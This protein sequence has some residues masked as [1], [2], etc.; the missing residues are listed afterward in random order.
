MALC[1][2]HPLVLCS[3]SSFNCSHPLGGE[4]GIPTIKRFHTPAS[5]SPMYS[6]GGKQRRRSAL[7]S[8]T[9]LSSL[10][11]AASDVFGAGASWLFPQ[12]Q[13]PMSEGEAKAAGA[14]WLFPQQ[15]QPMAEGEGKAAGA[16][17]YSFDRGAV[18]FI[19]LDSE[20]PSGP[21]SGQGR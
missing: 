4:C 2:V 14:P 12:K 6:R 8:S 21:E 15:Q 18:H 7:S 1:C 9:F 16:L 10:L 5:G 19:I 20:M 13:Q 11:S 17:Y 3:M